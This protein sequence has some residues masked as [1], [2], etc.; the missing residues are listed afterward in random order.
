M[1]D[2]YTQLAL[3][4]IHSQEELIGSIAWQQASNV[5]GLHVDHEHLEFISTDKADVINHLVGQ[6]KSIFGQAAVEVCKQAS[7]S[8]A[9][10]NAEPLPSILG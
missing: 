2:Y 7:R 10:G 4:I 6:Y 9:R 1:E 8:I 3:A 5:E